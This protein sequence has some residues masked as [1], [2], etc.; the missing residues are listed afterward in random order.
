LLGVA[1]ANI[2]AG[3]DETLELRRVGWRSEAVPVRRGPDGEPGLAQA[4]HVGGDGVTGRA[5]RSTWP[6]RQLERGQ[7]DRPGCVQSEPSKQASGLA[8]SNRYLLLVLDLHRSEDAHDHARNLAGPVAEAVPR[9]TGELRFLVRHGLEEA[10]DR[11]RHSRSVHWTRT[12]GWDRC[13]DLGIVDQAPIGG[14]MFP[15]IGTRR[16]TKPGAVDADRYGARVTH[17]CLRAT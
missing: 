10:R 17:Q 5:R 13:L 2:T 7:R 9:P 4:E 1:W 8:P 16:E 11:S 6:R 14:S 12:R 3:G 15:E